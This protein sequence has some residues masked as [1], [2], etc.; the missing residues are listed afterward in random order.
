MQM[1]WTRKITIE[2]LERLKEHGKTVKDGR[3]NRRDLAKIMDV[4]EPTIFNWLN[5]GM[6]TKYVIK[7]QPTKPFYK[8]NEVHDA[9]LKLYNEINAKPKRKIVYV[10]EDK[11]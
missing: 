9:L 3:I 2:R 10:D 6:I 8:I 11:S 5:N 4:S 7:E 1:K